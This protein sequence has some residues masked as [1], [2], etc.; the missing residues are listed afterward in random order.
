MV[1]LAR[2][3]A[4]QITQ[5]G[6]TLEAFLALLLPFVARRLVHDAAAHNTEAQ[7]IPIVARPPSMLRLVLAEQLLLGDAL[8]SEQGQRGARLGLLL[9]GIR[10]LEIVVIVASTVGRDEF[11]GAE[12]AIAH[13]A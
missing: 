3:V 8:R 12:G 4:A 7:C 11:V 1:G 2:L 6:E 5:H 10:L 13:V 9:A